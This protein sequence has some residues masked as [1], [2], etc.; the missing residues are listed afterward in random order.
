M[1]LIGIPLYICA[2][3]STPIVAALIAKGMGPEVA[4][5]F[6]LAGPATNAAGILVVGKF[7]G[8]RSAVIYLASIAICPVSLGLLLNYI[9]SASGLDIRATLG[10]AGGFSPHYIKVFSAA[11]LVVLMIVSVRKANKKDAC[12]RA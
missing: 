5:V 8:K 12:G 1:L 9:Y 2:S 7:L 10:K 3:A 6:L 4:P 11:L